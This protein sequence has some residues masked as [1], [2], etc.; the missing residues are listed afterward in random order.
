MAETVPLFYAGEIRDVPA[1]QAE[2]AKKAGY[3]EVGEQQ[4][5]D[6]D[7][8]A[9]W[10]KEAGTVEKL[11]TQAATGLESA[12]SSGLGMF[13]GLA[14]VS[15]E[16]AM[17]ELYAL[18]G[19]KTA[20]EHATDIRRRT[21]EFG[22][23]AAVGEFGGVL[24]GG[25]A[26]RGLAAGAGAPVS[27]AA[28]LGLE[29][30][31]A[32]LSMAQRQAF[33]EDREATVEELVYSG[34]LGAVLG[35]AIPFGFAGAKKVGQMTRTGARK[36]AQKAGPAVQMGEEALVGMAAGGRA[37]DVM[38]RAGTSQA[39]R[40]AKMEDYL[41][42]FKGE[43]DGGIP[44]IT[45]PGKPIAS[46]WGSRSGNASRISSELKA[47]DDA[48]EAKFG[49]RPSS[50]I[51]NTQSSVRAKE[52]A[53][54]R[55]ETRIAERS[56][57]WEAELQKFYS[58]RVRPKLHQLKEMERREL[59]S[60]LSIPEKGSQK[61]RAEVRNLERQFQNK[62]KAMP[63]PLRKAQEESFKLKDEIAELQRTLPKPGDPLWKHRATLL[64]MTQNAERAATSQGA[65]AMLTG[66]GGHAVMG[67]LGA[68]AGV[69]KYHLGPSVGVGAALKLRKLNKGLAKNTA[70][71]LSG[72]TAAVRKARD[73]IK[74]HMPSDMQRPTGA[75]ALTAWYNS[76]GEG[77]DSLATAPDEA[78]QRL[79]DEVGWVGDVDGSILADVAMHSTQV[80][81]WLQMNR[82]GQAPR[83]PTM[84]NGPRQ[85][86]SVA[87]MM[88]FYHMWEAAQR[89]TVIYSQI[90]DGNVRN[91]TIEA[92]RELY[93]AFFHGVQSSMAE[94]LGQL[95]ELP[96]RKTRFIFDQIMGGH[97]AVMPAFSPGFQMRQQ[98]HVAQAQAAQGAAGGAGAPQ[99]PGRPTGSPTL[100]QQYRSQTQRATENIG[101][102]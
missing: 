42:A 30:G 46:Q 13:T 64:E 15:G 71:A 83:S 53:L 101:N 40:A 26:G 84:P 41:N 1:A 67:P 86:A 91:E 27:G 48:L 57:E 78:H 90:L 66:L 3:R 99:S 12:A 73:T 97:G 21:Q 9:K 4:L 92:V 11:Y 6:W 19:D 20:E 32:S 70:Q 7:A 47:Y 16:E 22:G 85:V 52:R 88:R 79:A 54:S 77:L 80:G 34:G 8:R 62:R 94:Q 82:P 17:S 98:E 25:A 33:L 31:A 14:G 68:L 37:S 81:Q 87:E 72:R 55:Q 75:A 60:G 28:A 43:A 44:S 18:T 61:L 102:P 93:P 96:P 63:K 29:G 36:V 38:G 89:P 76:V 51:P 49:A 59:A 24:L 2:A 65:G 56:Q 5:A 74:K 50:N 39:A 69:A 100:S 10:R 45:Q 95:T 35:A 58:S 23:T